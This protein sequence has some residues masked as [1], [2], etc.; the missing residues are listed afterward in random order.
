MARIG[1][2]RTSSG[3]MGCRTVQHHKS[4]FRTALRMVRVDENV[5]L[6]KCDGHSLLHIVWTSKTLLSPWP[7]GI[8]AV[9]FHCDSGGPKA[10]KM[11][12][13]TLENSKLHCQ[14]G[15]QS[16]VE[17]CPSATAGGR[18]RIGR[19]TNKKQRGCPNANVLP[20]VKFRR[21]GGNRNADKSLA[22]THGLFY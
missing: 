8:V 3:E 13:T 6:A 16:L 4:S 9:V 1:L 22:D 14:P 15:R 2:T 5:L 11:R 17:T 21:M 18:T 10:K 19:P 12:G 7:Y 20:M